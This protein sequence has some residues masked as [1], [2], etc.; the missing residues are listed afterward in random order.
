LLCRARHNRAGRSCDVYLGDALGVDVP[1]D[2]FPPAP[3]TI[4]YT[5]DG[6]VQFFANSEYT[7]LGSTLT[8]PGPPG[9]PYP[10]PPGLIAFNFRV[11]DLTIDLQSF[12]FGLPGTGLGSFGA[13]DGYPAWVFDLSGGAFALAFDNSMQSDDINAASLNLL[14]LPT[15]YGGGAEPLTYFSD[16]IGTG[17]NLGCVYTGMLVSSVSSVSSVREPP[18]LWVLIVGLGVIGLIRR[19]PG[20]RSGDTVAA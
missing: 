20:R 5:V 4:S 10:L 17:C 19:R 2:L 13:E 6:N 11:G 3:L 16:F 7:V 18:S 1:R 14:T 9:T 12:V 8:P 15:F